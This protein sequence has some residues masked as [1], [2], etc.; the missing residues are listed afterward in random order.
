MNETGLVIKWDCPL[1]LHASPWEVVLTSFGPDVIESP[2]QLPFDAARQMS[3]VLLFLHCLTFK[4]TEDVSWSPS[5]HRQHQMFGI[6]SLDT[7]QNH[8][9]FFRKSIQ[10]NIQPKQTFFNFH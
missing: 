10:Q 6:Y 1:T 7:D 4:S 2:C 9:Q 8:K 3:K 5:H